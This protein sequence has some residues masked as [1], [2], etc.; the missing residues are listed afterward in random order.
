MTSV[1]LF[2]DALVAALLVELLL[3]VLEGYIKRR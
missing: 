3:M 2:V 1:G